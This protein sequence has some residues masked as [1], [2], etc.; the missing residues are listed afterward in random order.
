MEV[1]ADGESSHPISL[2]DFSLEVLTEIL[3]S[4]DWP[5]IL[6]LRQTCKLL[7]DATKIKPIW[8]NLFNASNTCNPYSPLRLD[9]P[10]ELYT[11]QEL[12][13]LVLRRYSAEIFRKMGFY[14]PLQR[15]LNHNYQFDHVTLVNGGRWLLLA[16]TT[17]SVA[18]YDLDAQEP[19]KRVLI[20]EQSE[21]CSAYV[22]VDIDIDNESA[23]L[24]FNLAMVRTSTGH[25]PLAQVWRVNLYIDDAH[26][27][28]LSAA[29]L[30]CFH[31]EVYGIL[32][33]LSILGQSI[34]VGVQRI[35]GIK[36]YVE[37]V[38]WAE[39]DL[40][41]RSQPT[42]L[43]YPRTLVFGLWKPLG[44]RLLPASR[45]LVLGSKDICIYDLAS[46]KETT[47]IP[48]DFYRLPISLVCPSPTWD[49]NIPGFSNS[50]SQT[51]LHRHTKTMRLTFC[52][53]EAVL[54]VEIPSDEPPS[55]GLL[56]RWPRLF[57]LFRFGDM[58][59]G[60]AFA[61]GYSGTVF[62]RKPSFT[63]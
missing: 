50:L 56:L 17:G 23:S 19:M 52:T 12:E 25:S 1:Q 8:M 16:Y 49:A 20:S 30:S 59:W 46:M 14:P 62:H 55:D 58:R 3:E 27:A 6:R 54:G 15:S 22:I 31:V 36:H 4:L 34:A 41:N 47:K 2:L 38:G 18:Y 39:A 11:A 57:E 48:S 45:L 44:L 37:V 13:Y 7:S 5:D 60:T 21:I 35:G 10:I 28:S 51:Y 26:G 24:S 53:P 29:L 61:S 32:T 40:H 9:Q 42:S 63:C 33:S 43:S